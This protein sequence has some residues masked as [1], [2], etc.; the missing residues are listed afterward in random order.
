MKNVRSTSASVDASSM[1][2]MT[3]ISRKASVRLCNCLEGILTMCSGND[4]EL[5]DGGGGKLFRFRGFFGLDRLCLCL[6]SHPLLL[7]Q[8]LDCI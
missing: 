2:N 1:L 7:R 6:Y 8:C 5:L 4:V 3:L